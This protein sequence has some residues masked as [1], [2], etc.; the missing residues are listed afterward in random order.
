MK[1][2]IWHGSSVIIEEPIFGYGK[3]NN[4][5]GLGFYCTESEE[6]AKEWACQRP[7]M[8]GYANC[9]ELNMQDL[10]VLNLL[11]SEFS[12]LNWLAL[13]TSN[14]EFNVSA[15]VA[16]QGREYILNNFLPDISDYD[17]I[18]G[19][20]ADD[21]YFSFVRAFVNNLISL[22]QLSRAMKLGKL[23]EQIV[24]KTEKAFASLKFKKYEIADSGEYYAKR[25]K[26]NDAANKEFRKQ[27]E[28]D[29]I[30]GIFMRDIIMERVDM[31]DIRL[32]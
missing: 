27:Q 23:G 15:A 18:I 13:L 8:N 11:D 31:N 20:R 4:D 24:L 21:S 10:S 17:I 32:R 16:K 1:K 25:K 3:E 30:T 14:R 26:R 29:D 28:I 6:L 22:E 9:Y 12:T 5:Y 19:Y 7:A 2:I